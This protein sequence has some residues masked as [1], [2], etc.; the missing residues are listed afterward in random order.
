MAIFKNSYLIYTNFLNFWT[1]KII[2]LNLALHDKIIEFI[3]YKEVE[4]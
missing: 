4:E 3:N 1:T 2:C